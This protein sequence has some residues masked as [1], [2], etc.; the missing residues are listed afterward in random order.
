MIMKD[1][2]TPGHADWLM[3]PHAHHRRE[4]AG[5]ITRSEERDF[6]KLQQQQRIVLVPDRRECERLER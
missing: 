6:K 5:T 2:A 1:A 3:A 4:W